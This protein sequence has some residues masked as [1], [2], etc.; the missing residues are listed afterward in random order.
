[1]LLPNEP[2]LL[3]TVYGVPE[4][5][6]AV[7]EAGDTFGRLMTPPLPR[8][9]TPVPLA[10]SLPL[11]VLGLIAIPAF[12][13][14]AVILAFTLTLFEAFRVSFVLAFHDT[15]WLMLTLPEPPAVPA[16]LCRMTS[17]EVKAAAS[18][19]ASSLPP[20]A[21]NPPVI[22]LRVVL[23]GAGLE[24]SYSLDSGAYTLLRLAYLAEGPL[25]VGPMCA[26]PDGAGFDVTFAGFTVRGE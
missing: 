20:L 25:Q 23:R 10:V 12:A 4:I 19:A 5:T 17:P 24:V 13:P 21:A 7:A 11:L 15:F 2:R 3:I 1:M 14:F 8:L 22:R 16:L 6:N 9:K 26:S 18:V